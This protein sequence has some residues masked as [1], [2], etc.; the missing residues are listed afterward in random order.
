[1]TAPIEAILDD[2]SWLVAT[3]TRN[4]PRELTPDAPLFSRLR[5]RLPGFACQVF[6]YGDGCLAFHAVRGAPETLFNV[7][8]DTVPVAPGWSRDPF[9]LE[10]GSD[11]TV[12]LGAC[13]IKGAAAC[14]LSAAAATDA[15][16]A[17][18]FTTDEEAGTSVAVKGFL[19]EGI[20][21]DR[22]IVGE[23]T[24]A[25][26]VAGHRGIFSAEAR[27]TGTSGHASKGGASAVHAAAGWIAASLA[28]SETRGV[29]LNFGRI[30]GGVK[31]NM[32]AAD[33]TVLFGM[34]APAGGAPEPVV[35]HLRTL[36]GD[37]LTELKP[38]FKGPALPESPAAAE[39]QKT[40]QDWARA[41]DIP[42]GDPVDFWTE[43]SLFAAAGT[44]ALVLGPGD[45]AQAH[46]ADEWVSLADLAAAYE[47][48]LRILTHA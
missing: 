6:D 48:Y 10:R 34:R 19:G 1:M 15:P 4:P 46:A 35:D 32:V 33:C 29:R 36:A 40:L 18:L 12:G 16:A 38:R 7:H 22:V 2:L 21:Y 39:G 42:L 8:L 31:P 43:A 9:A 3:D 11:R 37:Q 30:E 47:L 27:F 5:E 44:P 17:F 25:K 26:A 20:A 23:P 14:L 13:D 24:S 28:T 45:I 41:R